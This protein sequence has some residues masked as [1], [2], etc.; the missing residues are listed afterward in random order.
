MQ[1]YSQKVPNLAVD[2]TLEQCLETNVR[3]ARRYLRS[4]GALN[5]MF[6]G[7]AP[8]SEVVCLQPQVDAATDKDRMVELVRQLFVAHDVLRYCV[9]SEAW[10]SRNVDSM[11]SQSPDRV[12]VLLVTVGDAEQDLS[13]LCRMQRNARGKLLRVDD[14]DVADGRLVEGRFTRLLHPSGPAGE[15]VLREAKSLARRFGVGVRTYLH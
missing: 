5:L 4:H 9:L 13:A 12:E 2:E 14:P 15:E 8:N 11:P 10:M 7:Y 3:F 6:V 1:T